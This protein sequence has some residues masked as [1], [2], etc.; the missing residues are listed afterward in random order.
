MAGFLKGFGDSVNKFMQAGANEFK[1]HTDRATLRAA[2]ASVLRTAY[3][4]GHCDQSEKTKGMTIMTK[5]PVMAHFKATDIGK[6]WGELNQLYEI[7]VDT[8]NIQA[9][10]W[11][12]A[13]A[14]KP[15][16]VRKM[17]VALACAVAGADG[18]FDED[19][20]AVAQNSCRMLNVNPRD[21]APLAAAAREHGISL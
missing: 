5:H 16:V 2:V 10:E 1:R 7:D 19:E 14:S 8:A 17:V 13:A 6:C 18:N 3:A 9:D 21:I 12:A 11:I 4:D 15:E 20:V